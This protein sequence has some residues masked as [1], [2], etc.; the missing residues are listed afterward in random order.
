MKLPKTDVV[1]VDITPPATD[2]G[3]DNL[4][5]VTADMEESWDFASERRQYYDL[6]SIRVLA[7]AIG[8]WPS[9]IKRCFEHLK[10]GSWIEIPDV[11]IGTFSDTFDWQDESSPL[12]RWYQCYRKGASAYGIDGFANQKR[13]NCLANIQFTRISSKFF[14]CYLDED[15]VPEIRDKEIARLVRQNMLGLLD[16]VT[17]AMEE[18]GQWDK[19]KITSAELQQLKEDAKYDIIQNAAS[20]R[21]YW[22]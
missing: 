19:L 17:K 13:A 11:T 1:G 6:I 22:T 7:S 12:M 10:P 3:L 9:L 4:T 2:F 20:R 15:A 14:T 21:Y 8:D 18:R 5:F 16:A